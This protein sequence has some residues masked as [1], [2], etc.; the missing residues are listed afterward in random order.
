MQRVAARASFIDHVQLIAQCP[1]DISQAA[2][3]SAVMAHLAACPTCRHRNVNGILV[4]VHTDIFRARL[5]HGL[6]PIVQRCALVP[7]LWLGA[8]RFRATHVTPGGGPPYVK[9]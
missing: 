2:A 1:I 5:L 8:D 3:H 6:P 4:H 7:T 9:P